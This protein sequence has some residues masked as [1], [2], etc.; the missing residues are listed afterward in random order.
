MTTDK[1]IDI[2]SKELGIR[3]V[4]VKAVAQL[5][6]DDATVPFIAR[7]RKEATG[8]LDEVAVIA[9]RDRIQELADLDKRKDAVIKSLT[10]QEKL[11]PELEKAVMEAETLAK[12]E[13]IYL[14]YRPKRRTRG[15]I[16]KEKGLEPLAE[17]IFNGADESP[18][19]LAG[20]F[21]N[22]EKG[23]A[24]AEEAL[25]GA[26]DIIAEWI[27]EDSEA[28][29]IMRSLFEKKSSMSSKATKA[30]E[31]DGGKYRDYFDWSENALNAPSHRILAL[32]RGAE[33]GF[34]SVHFLPDE[35]ESSNLLENLFVKK[36]SPSAEQVSSAAKDSCKRLMA[37]SMETEIKN[38]CKKKADKEAIKIFSQNIKELLL[39]S[40][41][42]EKCVLALDPG[43][44]TGSKL[45]VLSRQGDLL[46]SDTIYP[47]EPHNKKDESEKKIKSL[48]SKFK[49]EAIAIGNGTGGRELLSFCK[50]INPE[51]IIVTMVNESGA[52][53]YSA[54]EIARKE[55]PDHDLT[56]R[57]AVSIGRRLMDPLA[58]LVKIDPGSIGV[59]QYQHDVDQKELKKSLD[60]VVSGC[61]NA[62]GVEINTASGQLLQYVSGL[63]PRMADAIVKHR[64][65]SGPFKSRDDLRKISGIG[66]KSF[67]QAAG[68][69]RIRESENPLDR[70]AVHPESYHIVEKMA[71]DLSCSVKDLMERDDLREEII[72]KNYVTESTGIPT[73]TDIINELAKPGRD[74]RKDFELF[75]FKD[76]VEKIEDLEEGMKLPGVV[77][78]VTAFGAFVDIGVHQD[79][80]VHIS[81]L[82]DSY[83][84]N[85][86]NVVKVND[87]INV[88]VL[89]IDAARK[90]IS[91]S[92]KQDREVKKSPVKPDNI[93][94][95]KKPV[96]P[97][98]NK[99]GNN[100]NRKQSETKSTS[101]FAGLK[102]IIR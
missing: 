93:V 101:P 51:G 87:K 10:A 99:T 45:V 52:S 59:G 68:F 14:P 92:M 16:A 72:I 43:L 85:P 47:L 57:G 30:G 54:S 44:R 75:T 67:E 100:K 37:P 19:T 61:V 102:D 65:K 82:S 32:L 15:T 46:H 21:I 4:Q 31:K 95:N 3:P 24:D 62:V 38:I 17:R 9:I 13:D 55:F 1:N 22:S 70:S 8:S 40:P 97:Q 36:N 28:R 74:P 77:T 84:S 81:E 69:L 56:V 98:N 12:L 27:N 64:V 6:A 23:V 11:T 2:I 73:L 53:V 66:P 76:G 80:L 48:C 71:K 26:R 58:E 34:L 39:T 94:R 79:G 63:S 35:E 29:E 78:N 18:L 90:R 91:L 7:Y 33:E 50:K 5:L 42:G 96:S 49:V 89:D 83:V 20:E 25:Q 88:T 86:H 60:D 41:L